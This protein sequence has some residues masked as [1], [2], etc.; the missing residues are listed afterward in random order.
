MGVVV[1][2]CFG[3]GVCLIDRSRTWTRHYVSHT[4]KHLV[5]DYPIKTC[6]D[7]DVGWIV[8]SRFDNVTTHF[9]YQFKEVSWRKG[10]LVFI[11]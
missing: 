1:S 8:Y 9:D 7:V 4:G 3:Q 10:F 11:F 5:N 2:S 6:N